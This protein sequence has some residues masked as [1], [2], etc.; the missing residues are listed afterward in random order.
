MCFR[1]RLGVSAQRFDVFNDL[2]QL[3][4]M[5][6]IF[7]SPALAALTQG[8]ATIFDRL[9]TGKHVHFIEQS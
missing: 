6:K 8:Y 2:L 3:D 5:V 1:V 9:G 4:N 7:V